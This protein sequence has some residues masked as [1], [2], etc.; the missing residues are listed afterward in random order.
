[1]YVIN[2]NVIFQIVSQ[3]TK[4]LMMY[5]R[6]PIKLTIFNFRCN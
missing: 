6:Y 4:Y 1:M 2:L 3:H 5:E